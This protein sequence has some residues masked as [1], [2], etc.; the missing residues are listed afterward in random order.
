MPVYK[1]TEYKKVIERVKQKVSELGI[2]MVVSRVFRKNG[3]SLREKEV[4]RQ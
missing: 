3:C 4:N 2:E 1:E